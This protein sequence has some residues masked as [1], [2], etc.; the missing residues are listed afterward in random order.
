MRLRFK[1]GILQPMDY[2]KIEAFITVVKF[3]SF[4]KAA[5]ELHI[6]QSSISNYITSLEKELGT[7]L[8][9]R[10]TTVFS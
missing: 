3:A 1:G 9:N 2:R 5:N 8:L 4:S 10:S 6:S 7:V